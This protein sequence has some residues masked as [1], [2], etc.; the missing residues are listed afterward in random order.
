M[1]DDAWKTESEENTGNPR[2]RTEI[3]VYLLVKGRRYFDGS[4][5]TASERR[6]AVNDE[7]EILWKEAGVAYSKVF[8]EN[9]RV[10]ERKYV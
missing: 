6:M 2:L 5:Y 10:R 8:Y 9:I 7:T 4:N 3:F 1:Q